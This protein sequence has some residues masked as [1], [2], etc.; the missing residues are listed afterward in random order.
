MI[1]FWLSFCD[2]ERPDGQKFLG[3]AAVQADSFKDAVLMAHL[4]GYNPGG[5]VV[6]APIQGDL[7]TALPDIYKHRLLSKLEAVAI[8]EFWDRLNVRRN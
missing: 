4:G 3:C 6:G 8:N 1:G 2:N 7:W 5:E